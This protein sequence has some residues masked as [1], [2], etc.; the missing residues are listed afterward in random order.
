MHNV[1][2]SLLDNTCVNVCAEC[3]TEC[4][5]VD[6]QGIISRRQTFFGMNYDLLGAINALIMCT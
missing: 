6:K 2:N 4:A 3:G 5:F 1:F